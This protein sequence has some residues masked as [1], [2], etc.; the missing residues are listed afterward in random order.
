MNRN[1]VRLVPLSALVVAS[2]LLCGRP[3]QASSIVSQPDTSFPIGYVAQIFPDLAAFSAFQFDDFVTGSAFALTTLTTFGF[4]GGDPSQNTAITAEIWNGLPGSGSIVLSASGS[5]VGNNLL[6][7]F[8]GQVLPAGSYWL[9]A[10][11]TRPFLTGGGQ[12]FWDKSSPVTGSESYFYNP[13]GGF[14]HGTSPVPG[15]SFLGPATNMAF[16]LE[17]DP[18]GTV[19]PEPASLTLLGLGLLEGLRRWRQKRV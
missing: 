7:A 12:W 11:V 6:F 2:L 14:G 1:A 16:S 18:V 15:S 17:G 19:V 10:Y 3:A 9:T 8:G 4:E 13:G 5:E